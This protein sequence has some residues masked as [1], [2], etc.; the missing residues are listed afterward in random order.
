[1]APEV[2]REG[3]V[4]ETGEPARVRD[5]LAQAALRLVTED[6]HGS[7]AAEE[8]ADELRPVSRAEAHI[9]SFR[10]GVAD[11]VGAGCR[12]RGDRTGKKRE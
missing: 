1:M 7:P 8:V 6:D 4:P 12:R 9:S 5:P 11:A 3:R 10:A 2:D